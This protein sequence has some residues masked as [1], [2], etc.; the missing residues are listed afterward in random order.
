M[1]WAI[2]LTLFTIL[3]AERVL[4][5]DQRRP[6]GLAA[7]LVGLALV[8][9]AWMLVSRRLGQINA[10][11]PL[12]AARGYRLF[13]NAQVAGDLLFLTLVLR[14]TG[15]IESPM[16]VFYVFHM[17]ISSLL[18]RAVHAVLQAA[19]AVV[20][21]ASMGV[22]E[23]L[24]WLTPHYVLL[25]ALPASG[26][27]AQTGHVAA[28]IIALACGVFGTL[29]FSLR[30]VAALDQR[31]RRL[32][33]AHEALRQSQTAIQDIQAR[34]SRFMQTAAH[35]LKSPLAII[36]TL[37]SLIHDHVVAGDAVIATCEKISKRC[38]EGISAVT[39]LLT[40]ARVQEAT[41]ERH[42]EA[43]AHADQIVRK[44]Y[45]RYELIARNKGLTTSCEVQPGCSL[46]VRVHP[47]DLADCVDNLLDNAVKYTPAGGRIHVTV[48]SGQACDVDSAVSSNGQA[49]TVVFESD[50]VCITVEDTGTGIDPMELIE[51]NTGD[52]GASGGSI[53][54][55]F[56]RGN[57]ALQAGIP[58][59]GLGLSIVRVIVEQAGGRLVVRS[60][61][62]QGS[63]FTLHFPSTASQAALGVRDTRASHVV[64]HR[65]TPRPVVRDT[66]PSRTRIEE[67]GHA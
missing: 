2:L 15:G 22:G 20:L 51:P 61:P 6:S 34:R 8:N 18:L 58:G 11:D 67:T 45:H 36:Q 59:S 54:D 60:S 16:A 7:T 26:F 48:A 56:R 24:G 46:S 49:K 47:G 31:E 39:E 23:L 62:G 13:A 40:L 57:N 41:P 53:F 63:R 19:W 50:S 10:S 9:L 44:I 5:P 25:P 3:A 12:A 21:Y 38:Q 28:A 29:Y 64:V 32:R 17:A 30:I 55:A 42:R 33:S 52:H 66:E 1:R 35:Q 4:T 14:F 65:P 27:Y 37:A 43:T